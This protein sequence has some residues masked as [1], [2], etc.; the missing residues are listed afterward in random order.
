MIEPMRDNNNSVGI[1]FINFISSKGS[2]T[3]VWE[4]VLC[5]APFQT[6]RTSCTTNMLFCDFH[7]LKIT[8]PLQHMEPTSISI[9]NMR[10]TTNM[11]D[12]VTSNESSQ[13]SFDF[14]QPNMMMAPRNMT[15]VR[16]QPLQ[17]RSPHFDPVPFTSHTI[18]TN[19]PTHIVL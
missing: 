2:T 5:S 6:W 15:T 1:F 14:T 3:I 18:K 10:N 19:T 11:A 4:F 9:P 17:R 16:P 12:I 8:M 7:F 13:N